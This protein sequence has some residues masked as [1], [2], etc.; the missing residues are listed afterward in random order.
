MIK[1]LLSLWLFLFLSVS[2]L[3]SGTFSFRH[4]SVED[5][6]S[7]NMVRTLLHDKYGFIWVGTDM[8]LNRYDGTTIKLYRYDTQIPN[9]FIS[10]L[11]EGEDVIW[12]GTD[13]GLFLY[14]YETDSFS[15]FQGKTKDN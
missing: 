12:V 13:Q 9:G 4:L 7:S 1:N 5:G 6:L 3:F 14:S 15:A 8:G 2:P 11:F 10:A